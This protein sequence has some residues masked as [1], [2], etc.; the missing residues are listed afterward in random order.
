MSDTD[1]VTG[2][3][4]PTVTGSAENG[5]TV[6]LYDGATVIGSAVATGGAWSITSSALAQGN[7]SIIATARD[8]TGNEGAASGALAVFAETGAPATAAAS[9]ALSSGTGNS[10]TDLVT[11]TAAQTISGSLDANLAVGERV[12]LSLDGGGSWTTATAAIGATTWSLPA[13]L[14][15]GTHTLQVRVANA[16]DN[17]GPLLQRAATL[18]TTAPAVTLSSSVAQL[19]AGESAT[20]VTLYAGAAVAGSATTDAS[21]NSDHRYRYSFATSKTVVPAQ[22]G[23]QVFCGPET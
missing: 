3:A 2:D 16:V 21:G 6:T 15:A 10:S 12:E 9:V 5:A 7:H 11:R 19:K 1:D 17:A 4:T 18:D 14:A 20:R 23:T 8:S 13:T 22:A